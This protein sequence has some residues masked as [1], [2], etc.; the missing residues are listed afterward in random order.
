MAIS[1]YKVKKIMLIVDDLAYHQGK[2]IV[3][4]V[5]GYGHKEIDDSYQITLK[6]LVKESD[7][8]GT[9]Q[10]VVEDLASKWMPMK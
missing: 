6:V 10:F 3:G 7:R 4:K 5:M 2:E 8:D 9:K 1:S